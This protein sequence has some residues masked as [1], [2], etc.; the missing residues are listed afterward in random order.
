VEWRLRG[1][2]GIDPLADRL[3]KE[4]ATANGRS[5]EALLTLAD[6][7][8]ALVEVRYETADGALS[9]RDFDDVYRPF[10]SELSQRMA[11]AVAAS[12]A[13]VAPDAVEF[14]KR[15]VTRCQE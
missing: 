13:D 11:I 3:L 2:V 1:L 12:G 6:F 4:F 7:L 5:D 15:V 10:L 14:W 9:R 8:L